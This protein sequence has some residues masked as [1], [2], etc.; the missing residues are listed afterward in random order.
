[1]ELIHI[2]HAQMNKHAVVLAPGCSALGGFRPL[3]L[4]D[5][6]EID[7]KPIGVGRYVV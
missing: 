2:V 3:V 4:A 7:L 1:M 6:D 5:G